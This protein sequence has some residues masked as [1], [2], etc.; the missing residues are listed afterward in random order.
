M[1]SNPAEIFLLVSIKFR[2]YDCLFLMD[3]KWCVKIYQTE[4][5]RLLIPFCRVLLKIL[6]I[7]L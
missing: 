6:V 1:K 5:E 7:K 4:I 3:Q 2:S